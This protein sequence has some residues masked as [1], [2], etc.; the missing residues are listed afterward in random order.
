MSRAFKLAFE[1][2]LQGSARYRLAEGLNLLG[3]K[4]GECADIL[5]AMADRLPP[6]AV[7]VLRD[8][9]DEVGRFTRNCSDLVGK[10]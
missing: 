6:E 4:I 1:V 8:L 7:D 10:R 5:D 9:F 3:A 2:P